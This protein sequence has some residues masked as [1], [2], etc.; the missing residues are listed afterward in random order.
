MTGIGADQAWADLAFNPS[1][2]PRTVPSRLQRFMPL[3]QITEKQK[4]LLNRKI[5]DNAFGTESVALLF[6]DGFVSVDRLS[7]WAASWAIS[8]IEEFESRAFDD[9]EIVAADRLERAM[10]AVIADHY[11]AANPELRQ[12]MVDD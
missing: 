12:V 5:M 3:Q 4:H 8:E 1:R 2:V 7:S 11:R 10:K 9:A 6:G